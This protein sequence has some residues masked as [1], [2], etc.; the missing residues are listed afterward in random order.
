MPV[1][2][3][4]IINNQFDP[5]IG[6]SSGKAPV[7]KKAQPGNRAKAQD[8]VNVPSKRKAEIVGRDKPWA[9]KSAQNDPITQLTSPMS[10]NV[11]QT[12]QGQ[13][14]QH[15]YCSPSPSHQYTHAEPPSPAMTSQPTVVTTEQDQISAPTV[16]IAKHTIVNIPHPN[17]SRKPDSS[18][19][20]I[21]D[22]LETTTMEPKS[23]KPPD[24]KYAFHLKSKLQFSGSSSGKPPDPSGDL[25]GGEKQY[26]NAMLDHRLVAE[27]AHW[28]DAD[29]E[30]LP[31]AGR[32]DMVAI[33]EPRTSG[34]DAD[35]IVKKIGMANSH[36]IEAVGYSGGIW[37]LWVD[38]VS[39]EILHNDWQFLH[40]KVLF[41]DNLWCHLTVVYGSPQPL[42]RRTLW[43]NLNVFAGTNSIPWIIMGDFNAY[44]SEQDK[45][46]GRKSYGC[47]RFREWID[48]NALNDPGFSGSRFTW[49][50]GLVHERIDRVFTND[51]W[52]D[53]FMDTLAKHLPRTAS[54]HSPLLVK[55][56]ARGD[57]WQGKKF[58]KYWS[59]WEAH[60]LWND[61]LA[62][63]WDELSCFPVA[64][65]S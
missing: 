17:P 20:I 13:D 15:A 8:P 37:L 39:V 55:F 48:R 16:E 23:G 42:T 50:R 47:R 25:M 40:V 9:K 63:H 10:H 26:S 14:H 44:T 57:R 56:K 19:S 11:P 12:Q 33:F 32:M 35:A 5:S 18:T 30:T 64:I 3:L 36:R 2:A 38:T 62:E 60:D 27:D 54:D 6:F 34:S 29:E 7:K 46:G 49:Q 52:E 28:S 61:W 53:F 24:P 21:P 51:K 45:T 4:P 1:S 59:A 43:E 22:N 65:R 58:F 31:D 41:Q